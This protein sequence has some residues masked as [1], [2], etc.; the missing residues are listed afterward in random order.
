[1]NKLVKVNQNRLL[2]Y[3]GNN[4]DN[5]VVQVSLADVVSG[6]GA[7][8]KSQFSSVGVLYQRLGGSTDNNNFA[9]LPVTSTSYTTGA[10]ADL[11]R[12]IMSRDQLGNT[13]A[14]ELVLDS[15]LKMSRSAANIGS[16]ADYTVVDII[17][18][19]GGKATVLYGAGSLQKGRIVVQT[20]DSG[21]TR[22]I[23][24]HFNSKHVFSDVAGGTSTFLCT[25]VLA[26]GETNSDA[27]QGKI[28][29]N[30]TLNGSSKFEATY[31]DLAEYHEGDREYEVGTVLVFGG[32]KEVTTTKT[33]GDTR[34]AGVVSN[35]AAYSMN[36]EC[37]GIKVCIALQGR[38]PV[39]VV[40][41]VNKGDM[42]VTSNIPGVAIAA[43]A[44]VRVGTV[45][46]KAIGSY[47]SDRI[48]TV[49]VSI[50]RT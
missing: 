2:G 30:W 1:M 11:V 28:Y 7:V 23:T 13:S 17:G 49:E 29:G 45:I 27:D 37:S 35:T 9:V 22:D 31:A 33:H 8:L 20:S 19:T 5:D 10:T 42:L 6:G 46:G 24:R 36:F 43:G 16:G 41:K 48:G 32:D 44:D 25:P 4:S 3:V 47:D 38:V 21:T 34:V 12:T 50:G 40:G 18:V 14:N 15:V 26:A 39:R